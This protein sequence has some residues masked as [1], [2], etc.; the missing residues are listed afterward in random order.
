MDLAESSAHSFIVRI[1]L[2]ETSEEAAKATWRGD[3]THV[4][5]GR[6]HYIKGI[7]EVVEFM[8]PY[9]QEMGVKSVG[10]SRIRKWLG[11]S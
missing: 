10:P 7:G 5:S 11:R 3:I 1:W 9:F 6:R 2:E 4:T 8:I